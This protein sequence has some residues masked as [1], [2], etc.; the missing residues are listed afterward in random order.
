MSAASFL[1]TRM[2]QE[3]YYLAYYF[4]CIDASLDSRACLIDLFHKWRPARNIFSSNSLRRRQR[5]G[6]F[7]SNERNLIS[8][9]I[10]CFLFLAKTYNLAQSYKQTPNIVYEPRF[11]AAHFLHK[12]LALSR[13]ILKHPLATEFLRQCSFI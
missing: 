12:Y 3:I 4:G 9:A 6:Y 10:Q 13:L 7:C 8:S 11:H 1:I 5:R 2:A